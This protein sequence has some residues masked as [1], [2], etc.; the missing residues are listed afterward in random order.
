MS[1]TTDELPKIIE[2]TNNTGSGI[3]EISTKAVH[4]VKELIVDTLTNCV[5]KCMAKGTFPDSLKIAK[6]Y[7][8]YKSGSKFKS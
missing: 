2:K 1:E 5:N 6:V 4:C 3:D 7:P 8:I